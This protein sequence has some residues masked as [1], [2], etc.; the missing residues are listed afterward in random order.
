MST[1]FYYNQQDYI[2]QLNAM[3]DA[4][5]TAVATAGTGAFSTLSCSGTTTLAGLNSSGQI[6][7]SVTTGTAPFVVASTTVVANLK[8]ATVATNANLTGDV[9]SSGNATT[10]ASSGV[11]ANTYGDSSHVAQVTFDIKGRATGAAAVLI[12]PAA[13]GA[14]ATGVVGASN[15]VATLNSSGKLTSA[16]IPDALVGAVVYQGTWNAST[17]SPTLVSGTGTKGNY[18]KVSVAGTTSI[19]GHATWAVDDTIIFDGV[20]WDKIGASGGAVSSV[21][22]QT[23][24]VANLSGE[25]TTSGSSVVTLTNSAVIGK[26]LTGFTAGAGTVASTDTILQAIQKLA[27]GASAINNTPIGST[28]PSTGAFT[29]LSATGVTTMAAFS[30]AVAAGVGSTYTVTASDYAVITAAAGTTTLTLPSAAS[31]PGR[32][33]HISNIVAQA[34]VSASSNV[35]PLGTTSTSTAILGAAAGRWC[36]MQSDGGNWRIMRQG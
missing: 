10:L 25:A 14:V 26:V 30:T 20:V 34:A 4:F 8:A 31:Y 18:Y 16:Q 5:A 15:G 32:W 9:T 35:I 19:D 12:T 2:A 27:G 6:T 17:N 21:F 36:D 7:S 11:T 29:S 22:G 1:R 28:T 24:V 13:I 23:G 33:L 3:D